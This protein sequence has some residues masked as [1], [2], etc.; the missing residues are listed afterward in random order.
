MRQT[1]SMLSFLAVFSLFLSTMTP[2]V[3]AQETGEISGNGANSTNT[4]NLTEKQNVTVVQNNTATVV[5]T[6]N[7][8]ATSGGNS[9]NDNTGGDV[10]LNTGSA[11]VNVKTDTMVNAN[12]AEIDREVCLECASAEISGNGASSV[13]TIDLTTKTKIMA[14]QENY[15]KITNDINANSISGQNNAS[16]NTDGEVSL[17]TG[18]ATVNAEVYNTANANLLKIGESLGGDNGV[19]VAEIS[20]NGSNSRNTVNQVHRKTISAVQENLSEIVNRLNTNAVSGQ[21]FANDNTG[22]TVGLRTGSATVNAK[23]DNLANF[24]YAGIECGEEWEVGEI[25]SNGTDS[26]N[27]FNQA[28]ISD[29]LSVFQ[30]EEGGLFSAMN[31]VYANP[32]SGNNRLNRNTDEENSSATILT[33]PAT[34]NVEVY[35]TGGANIYSPEG[36]WS[37]LDNPWFEFDFD[38]NSVWNSLF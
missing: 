33:S 35:T 12:V 37:W 5:N 18:P 3:L 14:F 17:L 38:F 19:V 29:S 4:V 15:A 16:R 30:N 22:G 26:R 9:L 13:N 27:A 2:W 24:N 32:L 36:T 20:G 34:S 7:A 8:N 21:N 23:V 10:G 25:F 11:T 6:I 31:A 28:T 1:K